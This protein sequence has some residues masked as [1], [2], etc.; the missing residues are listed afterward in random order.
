MISREEYLKRVKMTARYQK[1]LNTTERKR[2]LADANRMYNRKLKKEENRI[3]FEKEL[4]EI[5]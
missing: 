5:D 3:K 1:C 2:M 4:E